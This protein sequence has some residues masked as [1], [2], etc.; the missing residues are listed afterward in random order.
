M[1]ALGINIAAMYFNANAVITA[2]AFV[3]LVVIRWRTVGP[4]EFLVFQPGTRILAIGLTLAAGV[5]G[6]TVGLPIVTV[7]VAFLAYHYL[8]WKIAQIDLQGP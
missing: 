1:L 8:G 6:M 4:Q 5:I 3:V 2:V 7:A